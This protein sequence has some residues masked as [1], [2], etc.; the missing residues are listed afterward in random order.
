MVYRAHR[1]LDPQRAWRFKLGFALDSGFLASNVFPFTIPWP[2]TTTV[3]TNLGPFPVQISYV[4]TDMV[5]VQLTSKPTNMILSFV[6]AEDEL[7]HRFIKHFTCQEA[8]RSKFFQRCTTGAALIS[9]IPRKILSLSS[10]LDFT[11]MCLRKVCAILPKSVS[12]RLSQ[13]P[14]LGVWT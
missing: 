5:S 13:D 7:V 10:A 1:P 2:M 11:L 3:Q 8:N 12:T 9:A 6:A 14:C 4:N